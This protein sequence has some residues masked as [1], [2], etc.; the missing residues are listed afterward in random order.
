MVRCILW[1]KKY[2]KYPVSAVARAV[3]NLSAHG[4]A[5]FSLLMILEFW[6]E[7][8]ALMDVKWL[9]CSLSLFSHKDL[10]LPI[11][12]PCSNAEVAVLYL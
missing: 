8:S 1:S 6:L 4:D 7:C 9:H 3:L 11:R 10:F 12:V 5:V 2:G